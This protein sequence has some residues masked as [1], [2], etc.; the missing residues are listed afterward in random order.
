MTADEMKLEGPRS[1][2][3]EGEDVTPKKD[4]GVLKV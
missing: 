4:G 2:P 1:N 3:M